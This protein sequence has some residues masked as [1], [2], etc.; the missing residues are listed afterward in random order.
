MDILVG[1]NALSKTIANKFVQE[2]DLK[3]ADEVLVLDALDD[4]FGGLLAEAHLVA[5]LRQLVRLVLVHDSGAQRLH[6]VQNS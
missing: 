3:V 2:A 6:T 4:L 1:A 5:H